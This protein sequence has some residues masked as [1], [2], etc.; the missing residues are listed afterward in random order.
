MDLQPM[1]SLEVLRLQGLLTTVK[2]IVIGVSSEDCVH[3]IKI[4]YVKS[5]SID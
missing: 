3:K 5:Q 2:K 4:C 1:T